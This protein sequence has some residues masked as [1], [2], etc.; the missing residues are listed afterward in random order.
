[1]KLAKS[2][3]ELYS[4]AKEYDIVL[5]NDAPLATA[6]NARIDKPM[7]GMLAYTPR[8]LAA[9]L[10]VITEKEKSLTTLRTI[11]EISKLTGFDIKFVHGELEN[12]KDIRHYTKN[13][14]KYI[15]GSSLAIYDEYV[16]LTTVEKVM[17]VFDPET[18]DHGLYKGKRV[19]VIGVDLFDD[20]DKHF[21]PNEHHEID[22]YKSGNYDIET[23]REVGNDRQIAENAVDLIDP[24][25][26]D[27]IAIVMDTSGPIADAVRSALYRKHIPFKNNMTVKD[28]SQIRDYLQ[29]LS[30]A[31][32]YDTVRVKHVR[33]LFSAYGGRLESSKDEYYLHRIS[34]LL[35][36]RNMELADMLRDV[37]SLTFDQVCEVSMGI[38]KKGM[39]SVKVFIDEMGCKDS[40]V[41]AKVVSEMNYAVSNIND[42]HHNEQ[43][44]EEE[45][46]GVLLADCKNS[47]F[48]DRSFVIYLGIGPEWNNVSVRKPYVD[49]EDEE[50]MNLMKFTC[51]LQQGSARVYIVNTMRAGRESQPCPIFDTILKNT[52]VKN[53]SDVCTEIIKGPWTETL[54]EPIAFEG[55]ATGLEQN[56]YDWKFSKSTFNDYHAC[57]RAYMFGQI[58]RTPENEYTVLGNIIH[59]FAEF[60]LCYPELVEENGIDY[61][62]NIIEDRFSGISCPQMKEVDNSRIRVCLTNVKRFIDSLGLPKIILD[63]DCSRR[64]DKNMFMEMHGCERYSGMMETDRASSRHMVHGR[65]DLLIDGLV[66]DYKTGNPH[67]A[68]KIIKKMDLDEKNE[69]FES[70]PMIY[71]ALVTELTGNNGVFRLFYAKENDIESVEDKDYDIWRNTRDI[72][73]KDG[74]LDCL[75]EGPIYNAAKG[76]EDNWDRLVESVA[77]EGLENIT[78]S[79]EA[80]ARRICT[81]VGMKPND[82]TVRTFLKNVALF[83]EK[84]I[85]A[86]DETIYVSK[87]A[88]NR[89]M[90]EVDRAHKAASEQSN[91]DFPAIPIFGCKDCNYFK[92][93][94]YDVEKGYSEGG[95]SDE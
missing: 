40:K 80:Q 85:C 1:M 74:E 71:L 38:H 75:R 45:K 14:R 69:R 67:D 30:L 24:E 9:T 4:E 78:T 84:G 83:N 15:R 95:D 29:F 57:P 12:I 93:C 39:S 72:I 35:T 34:E 16:R 47:V 18:D 19:A 26:A 68:K 76:V 91:T 66:V 44:P 56:D 90:E 23:I 17:D 92:A 60:Y 70:Q 55:K 58:M 28:L 46:R 43:I 48:I 89:F 73:L 36:G 50:E 88:L 87:S 25:R 53:F 8:Q 11:T 79:D 6:I 42:L 82:S 20:L 3:E 37:R 59:D 31:L 65:F 63:R 7:I 94:T 41:T 27:D 54:E 61:Y 21:I 32:T 81:S 49:K 2:I 64:K 22:L 51:L 86:S 77:G 5:T 62:R 33:E 10:D 52:E 13:V